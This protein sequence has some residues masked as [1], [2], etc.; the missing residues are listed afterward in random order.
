MKINRALKLGRLPLDSLLFALVAGLASCAPPRVVPQSA[1]PP[2]AAPRPA[3][4]PR[5][6]PGPVDWR[7]APL[8]PGNWTYRAEPQGSAALY[9]AVGTEP[10]FALRCDRARAVITLSRAGS[11]PG[12]L[13]MSI[14][15]TSQLRPLSADPANSGAPTLAVALPPRDPVFDAM[16]YSRGRFAVE[17]NGLPTLFLP[18]WAEVGRVI[19]DCR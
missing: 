7:D 14:V 1:P 4:P 3:P 16:A 17:I 12:P 5:P 18:S 8:T 15:T 2:V 9:G 19:E 6:A 13:P 11:A 10:L